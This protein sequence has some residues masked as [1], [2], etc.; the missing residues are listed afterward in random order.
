[1]NW[2]DSLDCSAIARVEMPGKEMARPSPDRAADSGVT[3][4][5]AGRHFER[6]PKDAG[7][8]GFGAFVMEHACSTPTG[9]T[10]G[11]VARRGRR[12]L[13]RGDGY[14]RSSPSFGPDPP[15]ASHE[16]RQKFS[17]RPLVRASKAR[18]CSSVMCVLMA[19]PR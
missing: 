13:A 10:A 4:R 6:A 14:L 7:C 5:I 15:V 11:V 9:M 19:M 1:M 2:A 18:R 12:L 3:G 17:Q 16:N 8:S